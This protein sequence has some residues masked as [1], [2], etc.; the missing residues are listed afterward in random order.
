MSENNQLVKASEKF[1]SVQTLLDK[2]KPQIAAAL[3]KHINADKMVR[4]ALTSISKNPKLLE[5]DQRSLLGAVVQAAQL[6]LSPDGVLGEAYL[7]PFYNGKKKTYEV[8]FIVGYKGLVS[9][10]MRSGQVASFQG[11]VVYDSDHFEYELG[12]NE[13]LIHKPSGKK[14]NITHAYAVLKFNNGGQMFELMSKDE[15]DQIRDKSQNHISAKKFNKPSVWDEYYEEMAKKTV[16]RKLAKLAPLSPEFQTAVALDEQAEVLNKSQNNVMN[17]QIIPDFRNDISDTIDAEAEEI[18]DE[19]NSAAK[20][21]SQARST[22]LG[23]NVAS[24]INKPGQ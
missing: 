20:D 1:A 22:N 11:R 23:N 15:L 3:P 18:K 8:S 4:I 6:G 13:K 14:G 12:L 21:A 9:L 2:Y 7:V 19:E 17:L 5:C 10:A 16:V 24:K